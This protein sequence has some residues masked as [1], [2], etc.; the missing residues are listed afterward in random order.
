MARIPPVDEPLRPP[1]RGTRR[2][3]R[4][5]RPPDDEHEMD[6]RA[7]AGGARRAA[8]GVS[9]ARRGRPGSASAGPG[10]SATRSRLQSDCRICSTFF[11]RLLIDA[12][13]DPAAL[14]A[15]RLRRADR[16]LRAPA[17]RPTRMVDDC[18]TRACAERLRHSQIVTLIA[19]GAI[20]VAT[21]V[22][23]DA[24]ARRARRLPAAVRGMTVA[25]ITGAAHG[26]GRATALA[27]AP[28]GYDIVALDVGAPLEYHADLMGTTERA[29]LAARRR[30]RRRRRVPDGRGRRPRRR[31]GGARGAPDRALRPHRRA[32][33]QRRHLRLRPRA[34]VTEAEWDA[35]LDI[36]SR[37]R[38]SSPDA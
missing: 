33:Q 30:W 17:R 22:F 32:V 38:G 20:M 10:C 7:F 15:R 27:L 31:R 9:A 2:R 1:S 14:A 25:L 26:Q 19:S 24:L 37:A 13:E 28:D 16:G 18:S 12:G 36:T 4:G 23:N 8:A 6:A 35:M 11:R 5:H 34:R 21:N 29:R 3:A